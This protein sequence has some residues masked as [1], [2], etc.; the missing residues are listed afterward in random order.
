MLYSLVIAG[1]I[2]AVVG[3]TPT[4]YDSFLNNEL[5]NTDIPFYSVMNGTTM[6]STLNGTT[7]NGTLN[8]TEAVQFKCQY[9]D[10]L[11]FYDI[12]PLSIVAESMGGYFNYSDPA[13]GASIQVSFCKP[14][15]QSLY[16]NLQE[17][18]MA[19][20]NHPVEGCVK[21][22]GPSPTDNAKLKEIRDSTKDVGVQVQYTGGDPAFNFSV[23]IYCDKVD[24]QAI[25]A[26]YVVVGD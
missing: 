2:G 5:R 13:S 16:C 24:F 21:L 26:T 18:S 7:M 9:I 25:N 3:Q 14:L 11:D 12:Q 10:G 19:V 15:P 6:N 17:P 1:F 22:S 8:G 4:L 20:L 23:E